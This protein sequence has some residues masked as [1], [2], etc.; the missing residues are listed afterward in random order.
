M[1][2]ALIPMWWS[3]S[4]FTTAVNVSGAI[5]PAIDVAISG[6]FFHIAAEESGLN[7][8]Y[9]TNSHAARKQFSLSYSDLD[10]PLH[11]SLDWVRSS[12][13]LDRLG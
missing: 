1:G 3:V 9:L 2:L 7:T 10:A 8:W 4:K 6:F 11:S 13:Y 5:K 12:H